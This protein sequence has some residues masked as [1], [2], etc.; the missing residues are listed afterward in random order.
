MLLFGLWHRS[1]LAADGLKSVKVRR[2]DVLL[3]TCADSML[4]APTGC[5]KLARSVF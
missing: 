2:V 1:H 3:W 5:S 4:K